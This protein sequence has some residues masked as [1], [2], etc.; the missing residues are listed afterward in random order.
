[1]ATYI[2]GHKDVDL[3]AATSM[4]A[5]EQSLRKGGYTGPIHF[6]FMDKGKTFRGI[7][8]SPNKQFEVL[9]NGDRVYHV[10]CGGGLLDHNRP[11]CP[12]PSSLDLIAKIRGFKKS[13]LWHCW[14]PIIQGVSLVD[15]GQFLGGKLNLQHAMVGWKRL[16]KTDREM[17]RGRR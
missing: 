9:P 16:G 1:M 4:I 12:N 10:D 6:V 8:V 7:E 13:G 3:D 2:V 14:L 17:S 15:Q 11:N 5:L